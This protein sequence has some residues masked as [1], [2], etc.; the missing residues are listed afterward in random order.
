MEDSKE[1]EGHSPISHLHA[2]PRDITIAPLPDTL[3]PFATIIS[4]DDLGFSSP[5]AVGMRKPGRGAVHRAHI[6]HFTFIYTP[7]LRHHVHPYALPM[8]V[9]DHTRQRRR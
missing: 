6:A 9:L 2:G 5:G 1:A 8:P 3:G 7:R 4:P